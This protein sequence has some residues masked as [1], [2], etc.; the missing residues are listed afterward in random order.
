[1]EILNTTWQRKDKAAIRRLFALVVESRT[2]LDVLNPLPTG[3][4][5]GW[6]VEMTGDES[7]GTLYARLDEA[8]R[9]L[10]PLTD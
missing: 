3:D 2:L 4:I 1:M 7:T 5:G 6:L 9:E 8:I 10:G